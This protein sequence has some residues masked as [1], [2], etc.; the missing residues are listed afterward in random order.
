MAKPRVPTQMKVIRGTFRANEA[1]AN[2]PIPPKLDQAPRPPSHLNRWAKLMWKD[3]ASELLSLGMLAK[4]D[5]YSLEILCEQYG[6]Y[7]ELKDAITHRTMPD[8]K[9]KKISFAQYLAGQNSQTIPEYASMK[10]AFERYTALLKEFGLSP[11]S[12]SRMDI[13][14]APAK[15]KDPMEDLLEQAK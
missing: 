7:R 3:T 11:A 12:R 6:L 1:P 9:K 10:S 14:R 15:T 2:E 5:L 4:I 13:P 8:G